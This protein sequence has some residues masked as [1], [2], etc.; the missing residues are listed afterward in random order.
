[1][2]KFNYSKLNPYERQTKPME[3]RIKI[4]DIENIKFQADMIAGLSSVLALFLDFTG[5]DDHL[6][7]ALEC[8]MN[9]SFR[10]QDNCNSLLIKF[11]NTQKAKYT[12]K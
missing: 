3:K 12:A 10:M 6:K 8:L 4:S 5:E 7:G 2:I 11:C 9:E 1:M